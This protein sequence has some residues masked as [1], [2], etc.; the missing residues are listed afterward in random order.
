MGDW[1]L[2]RG[3][4]RE[5]LHWGLFPR[6]LTR[7]FPGDKITALD[8]PGNGA[9][10]AEKS[11]L[12]VCEMVDRI[13]PRDGRKKHLLA[14]SLGAMAAIDWASRVQDEAA[15][16]ILINPSIASLS[17][18]YERLRPLAW[19]AIARAAFTTD[20]YERERMILDLTSGSDVG[21]RAEAARRALVH[22][23]HPIS[24]ANFVRQILAASRFR[25]PEKKPAVPILLLSSAADKLVSPSCSQALGR[26]WDLAPQVHPTGGHD[27]PFDDTAWI[28]AHVKA[29]LSLSS[30]FP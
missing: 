12:S 22:E 10:F 26:A 8:L 20:A 28:V 2:L 30:P 9:R 6:A 3:L 19:H 11:P 4:C 7:E 24:R 16:L 5:S 23:S 18:P 25:L 29:F 21:L 14:I 1:I 17:K 13:R 15:S 27:L